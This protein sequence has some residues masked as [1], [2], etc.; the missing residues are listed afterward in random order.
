MRAQVG[1]LCGLDSLRDPQKECRC[2]ASLPAL[3]RIHGLP[4]VV[5]RVLLK[6]P[7]RGSELR[8]QGL[9]SS[10]LGSQSRA[11]SRFSATIVNE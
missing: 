10:P 9:A 4:D 8:E 11:H 6:S 1:P 7:P 5:P 3:S 2:P